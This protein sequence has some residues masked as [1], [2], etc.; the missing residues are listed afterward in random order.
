MS[1][2]CNKWKIVYFIIYRMEYVIY[3]KALN[4]PMLEGS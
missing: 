1:K 2:F 4:A 3:N